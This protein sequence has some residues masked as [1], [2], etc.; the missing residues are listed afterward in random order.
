MEHLQLLNE[1]YQSL[2]QKKKEM[3]SRIKESGHLC[4]CGYYSQHSIR[5]KDEWV[6]EEYPIPVITIEGIGDIGFDLNHI[7]YEIIISKEHA[8]KIDFTQFDGVCFEVY[9]ALDYLNDF[10][11]NTMQ[12]SLI[13]ERIH[14]SDEAEIGISFC[15]NEGV[16]TKLMEISFRFS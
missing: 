10:Y 6:T 15:F 11:N 7:F 14:R 13:H 8:L 4:T 9:G 3:I 12:I 5:I 16:D 2:N 1:I